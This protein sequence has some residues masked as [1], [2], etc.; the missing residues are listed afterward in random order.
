MSNLSKTQPLGLIQA[1]NDKVQF[2]DDVKSIYDESFLKF[3]QD[4]LEVGVL[5]RKTKFKKTFSPFIF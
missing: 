2:V 3:L 1:F 4:L 5:N